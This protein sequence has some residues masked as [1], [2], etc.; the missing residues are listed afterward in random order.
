MN[1]S[2]FEENISAVIA[3]ASRDID[4]DSYILRRFTLEGYSGKFTIAAKDLHIGSPL[5][6]F[7]PGMPLKFEWT[8]GTNV[9]PVFWVS[10]SEGLQEQG[11][12]IKFG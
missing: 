3:T 10:E 9:A 11:C 4:D 8:K 2:I 6:R 5:L 7:L 1:S 12:T